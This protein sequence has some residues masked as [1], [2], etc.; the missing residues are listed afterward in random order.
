MNVP[1]PF[2]STAIGV[3][4]DTPGIAA[5]GPLAPAEGRDT[6]QYMDAFRQVDN[7]L[8]ALK[9][10]VR[11]TLMSRKAVL[12]SQALQVYSRA[13]NIA[14]DQ[15]DARMASHVENLKRDLGKRGRPRKKR[16]EEPT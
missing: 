12:A 11:F 6:L 2:L 3:T 9:S 13:R 15:S 10:H 4:E 14:R 1:V 7:K 16:E 8:G 5:T